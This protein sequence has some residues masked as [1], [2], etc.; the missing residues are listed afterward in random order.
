MGQ[1]WATADFDGSEATGGHGGTGS[2][3][4]VTMQN[5]GPD[6]MDG[7]ADDVITKMNQQPVDVSLDI[8]PNS[9]CGDN[10]DRIRGFFSLHHG[11]AHF[12]LADGSVRF[13]SENIDADIYRS[14]STV[15]DNETTGD[16]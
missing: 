7:T 3:L 8:V 16:F 6:G 15:R 9:G 13:I 10:G 12:G 2:I 5:P 11:G 14:I 1:V 4:A